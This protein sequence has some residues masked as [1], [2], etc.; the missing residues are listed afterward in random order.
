MT[1]DQESRKSDKSA[2]AAIKSSGRYNGNNRQ[3]PV[4]VEIKS[5]PTEQ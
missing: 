4:Q 1:S 3:S 5:E 2:E